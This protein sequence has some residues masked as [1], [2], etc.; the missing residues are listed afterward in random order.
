M[1]FNIKKSSG[2]REQFSIKKF[3]RSLRR[4]GASNKEIQKVVSE[5]KKKRPKTTK[6]IHAISMRILKKEN[7][8]IADRY[9]LKHAIMALGP[10][11]YPFEKFIGELFRA[12]GYHVETSLVVPGTCVNHEVD[13]IAQ[14][15]DKHYMIET[16][17]HNR[18][19]IKSDIQVA[20]YVQAR[21]QDVC[22]YWISKHKAHKYR[23][24]WLIT[25]TK[26]TSQAIQYAECKKM[27]LIAW[28]YPTENNLAQLVEKYQL[29]PI[30]TLSLL[31]KKQKRILIQQ[32]VVM[33]KDIQKQKTMLK[34][35]GISDHKIEK[36]IAE[37]Q[38]VCK[39]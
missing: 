6:Q 36:I 27:R 26:F 4:A 33:C 12:Q 11:G 28:N 39:L 23:E 16:K 14:K 19:G 34:K 25:N 17:F 31:S 38:A 21:F 2:E 20:L 35:L 5:I 7:R 18:M 37:S 8:P 3:R 10:E 30:T 1:N 29:I 24:V 22:D 9:N 32:G 13:G 15:E